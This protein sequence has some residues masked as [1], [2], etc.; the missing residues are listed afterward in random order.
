MD[1]AIGLLQ[2]LPQAVQLGLIAV[3][4]LFVGSK[5]LSFLRLVLNTFVL[6]GVNVSLDPASWPQA[7]L[8]SY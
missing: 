1:S 5:V 2:R 4:A 3:G 6:S 7:S 8:D